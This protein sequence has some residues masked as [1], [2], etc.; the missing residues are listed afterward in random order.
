MSVTLSLAPLILQLVG[1]LIS[2]CIE[3]DAL[4]TLI[5]QF[6]CIVEQLS[7]RGYLH[8]DLS[9]Y[10]LLQHVDSEGQ[11][12]HD[13]GVRALLVDMQ[14]LMPVRQVTCSLLLILQQHI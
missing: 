5:K 4:L 1:R 11:H 3:H 6:A 12:Q 7:I 8:G 9:Y 14:T 10:N 2:S 13:Q